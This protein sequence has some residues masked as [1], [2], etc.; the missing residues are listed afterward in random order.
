MRLFL[1]TALTMVAFAANSILN[2]LALQDGGA[3]PASFAAIRLAS[4]A[5]MLALLVAWRDGGL[6]WRSG[7]EGVAAVFGPAALALYVLGFSFGYVTLPAGIGALILFGGVQVT[8]FAG[9]LIEGEVV[10][11]QRWAGAVLSL[12]GL[13]YLMWPAEAGAAAPDGWGAA[14]M[15]L[16]ALGWG[17]YSLI[18]RGTSDPLAATAVNFLWAVPAGA[19]VWLILPDGADARGV[20]LAVASGAVTS[21]LGY[22]LWYQV[23]P[24]LGATRAA[25]AQLCVPVIAIAGGALLLSEPVTLRATVASALVLG[26]VALANLGGRKASASPRR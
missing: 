13:F 26:G 18:G 19:L 4:G 21:G 6:R 23:M 17:I 11:V 8:M 2:R 5:M 16:A 1:L 10:P 14:L 7:A 25:V 9:A 15:A 20:A 24:R 22:A 3:G 12:G